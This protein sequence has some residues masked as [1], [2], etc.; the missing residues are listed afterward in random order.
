MDTSRFF[1]V[2]VVGFYYRAKGVMMENLPNSHDKDLP[3]TEW[4]ASLYPR[5]IV[6]L[7]QL[8]AEETLVAENLVDEDENGEA[9]WTQL[10]KLSLMWQELHF[11]LTLWRQGRLGG[12][13]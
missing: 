4:E 1:H 12:M 6:E 9:Y 13:N 3:L 2:R 7:R 8:I 10:H 5:Q 11:L